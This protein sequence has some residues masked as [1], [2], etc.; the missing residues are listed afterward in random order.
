MTM[1][2]RKRMQRERDNTLLAESSDLGSVTVMGLAD[3]IARALR[4]GDARVLAPMLVEAGRRAG[5][6]VVC[7]PVVRVVLKIQEESRDEQVCA[8]TVGKPQG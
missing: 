5:L 1:A 7:S 2:Q 3:A 4:S 8:R 6:N